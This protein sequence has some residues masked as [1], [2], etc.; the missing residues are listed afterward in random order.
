M[1]LSGISSS[2]AVPPNTQS[3]PRLLFAQLAKSLQSGDL[4]GAQQA[5]GQLTQSLGTGTN[6]QS[7]SASSNDPFAQALSTIGQALQS[8]D[9]S[10]AQQALATLQQQ[11]QASRGHHHHG[12]RAGGTASGTSAPASPPTSAPTAAGTG[13]N[14][15]V[16]A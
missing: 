6:T 10:G 8:G 15:D 1:A 3:D 14:L 9:L 5:Y 2:A 12:H 7:A 11:S 13:A 4:S 16:T